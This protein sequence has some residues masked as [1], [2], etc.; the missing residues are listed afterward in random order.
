MRRAADRRAHPAPDLRSARCQVAA[1][2]RVAVD[3]RSRRP[4]TRCDRSAH[5]SRW[6]RRIFEATPDTER[7]QPRSFR[8]LERVEARPSSRVLAPFF[9]HGR[10]GTGAVTLHGATNTGRSAGA[11]A[12]ARRATGGGFSAARSRPSSCRKAGRRLQWPARRT[13]VPTPPQARSMLTGRGNSL[14]HEQEP[15]QRGA[16]RPPRNNR[17]YQ[18]EERRCGGVRAWP[19]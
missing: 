16:Q 8:N 9:L 11:R 13:G 6:I 5:G 17:Q 10:I 18:R 3:P 15:C 2:E 19:R 7:R 14:D 12:H 1:R 4:V